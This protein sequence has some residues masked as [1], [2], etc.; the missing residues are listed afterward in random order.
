MANEA[1]FSIELEGLNKL[2]EAG[3]LWKGL[4]KGGKAKLQASAD[5]AA[6]RAA[7][8]PKERQH[9]AAIEKQR[10]AEEKLHQ[11]KIKDQKAMWASVKTTMGGFAKSLINF[12]KWGM[13]GVTSGMWGIGRLAAGVRDDRQLGKA[14]GAD[15]SIIMAWN[16]AFKDV[17]LGG[18]G[19]GGGFLNAVKSMQRNMLEH[20]KF[21]QLGMQTGGIEKKGTEQVA[22]QVLDALKNSKIGENTGMLEGIARDLGVDFNMLKGFDAAEFSKALANAKAITQVGNTKSIAAFAVQLDNLT[23]KIKVGF[24]NIMGKYSSQLS[25]FVSAFE[26]WTSKFIQY[27]A[28]GGMEKDL[29]SAFTALRNFAFSVQDWA[30]KWIPGVKS[31]TNEGFKEWKRGNIAEAHLESFTSKAELWKKSP[32]GKANNDILANMV[33]KDITDF[34]N[35]ERRLGASNS[36]IVE[37]LEKIVLAIG[38]SG[39]SKRM[40]MTLNIPA[41]GQDGNIAV[42]LVGEQP[43]QQLTPWRGR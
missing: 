22:I 34:I 25:D 29:K 30:S 33:S 3:E 39:L 18:E 6:A 2:K 15:A 41:Q 13:L 5:S 36:E 28:S 20:Y 4:S 14:V 11:K 1:V 16:K 19:A 23:E 32:E 40:H 8:S 21:A 35:E 7:L 9:L 17:N 38:A 12:T 42:K 43:P 27:I 26:N 31:P 24:I 10:A 37:W